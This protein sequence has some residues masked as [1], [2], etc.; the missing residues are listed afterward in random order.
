[1]LPLIFPLP[2]LADPASPDV[3]LYNDYKRKY[4]MTDRLKELKKAKNKTKAIMTTP[5]ASLIKETDFQR[6]SACSEFSL[7]YEG[8][9]RMQRQEMLVRRC[10]SNLITGFY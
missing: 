4:E 5:E 8:F 1:M 7:T 6:M 3:E 2:L 9:H 10:I